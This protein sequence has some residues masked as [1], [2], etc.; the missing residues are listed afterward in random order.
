MDNMICGNRNRTSPAPFRMPVLLLA[1]CL[2]FLAGCGQGASMP[3]GRKSE[4]GYSLPEI[5]VI[6]MTEQNRYEEICTDQI[7][8]VEIA[9]EGENFASYLT[10]QIKNFM[11]ELKI[12]NLLAQDRNMS[13]SPEE[14]S[15][16]AAAAAEYFGNL[17]AEDIEHMGVSE[18]DVIAVFEDYCLAEKLVEELTNGIDLEVSDSEAKVITVMQAETADRQTA[19]NLSLAAA[20]ENADFEKCA[21]DAGL[22][23]TTR[24]LG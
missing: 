23:A 1:L 10:G 6:A 17:T 20:Q 21:S 4:K 11:E 12:M 2:L 13:L 18:E 19:E 14:R 3:A 9:E 15:E 5:M 16:M 7:W 24:Q 8:N 22:S